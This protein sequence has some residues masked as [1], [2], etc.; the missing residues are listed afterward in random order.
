MKRNLRS[1]CN[2][3]IIELSD[4]DDD[5]YKISKKPK[6]ED[7]VIEEHEKKEKITVDKE[8]PIKKRIRKNVQSKDVKR[9]SVKRKNQEKSLEIFSN[10][11]SKLKA[12]SSTD[13]TDAKVSQSQNQK[14]LIK[15]DIKED[16][17]IKEKFNS[18]FSQ[19]AEWTDVD[20]ISEINNVDRHIVENVV[21]LFKEDNTIPFIARYRKNMTGSMEADQLR[22]LLDSFEQAK[23]IK[24]RAATIIKS[25]DK[26]G[27][28]SPE[29]HSTITS[30]KS[31]ADLEHIYSL[32]KPSAS[33]RLLAEKAR[34]LG[35]GS[36]SDAI[37]QG[38]KIAPLIF[39]VDEQREGLRNEQEVRSGIVH[40]IADLIS[41]D[42][43]IF[44]RV[45]S[46]RKT[47]VI[48]IHTTECKTTEDSKNVNGRK[49]EQYFN[50]KSRVNAIKPHHIL[51]IN[52]AESQKIISVKI[53]I[54]DAFERAFKECC[55]SRYATTCDQQER[56]MIHWDLLNESIDHAY[57]KLI[58][59]QVIRRVRS[60]MKE[61]AEKASIEVFATNVKQLLLTPPVRGK[62]VLGI[63]PGYRHGCKLA[64]VS[65]QGNVL[66]T[67]VIYPHN[68]PFKDAADALA[69]LVNK[70]GCA[71]IALGNATACRETELFLTKVIKSEMFN[72][73]NVMYTIVDECGASIYSCS[74]QAKSEFPDLDP[75]LVSA[76]SIA[77]RLQ[78]PLAELVKIEPKHLGVGMYQHD[79]PEA[80]LTKTLSEII[81]EVVS[82]VGVDINTASLYLL[83]Q[84][85]GLTRSRSTSIIEWRTKNGPFKNREELL[86]V[87]GIGSKTYE[88]CAGF[89]RILPETAT[90]S[91]TTSERKKKSKSDFNPLDQTW[92][93][94]E[95]YAIADKF[96]KHCQCKL[97][98][99]GTPA[100][101]ERINSQARTGYGKLAAQYGTDETTMET[102]IKAL[103]MQKDE[104]IRSKL[105]QPLFRNSVRRIEDLTVGTV[106]SG[107]VRNV[108][109]F[110][111]FVDVGVGKEG[112]IH[113]TRMK[114][115]LH[116]GQRVEVKVVNVELTRQ[117]IG[118]ELMS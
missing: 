56:E 86:N 71:I 61:Y 73:P 97:N 37:L 44:D 23:I 90:V 52:R 74:P 87:K 42:K 7:Y 11:K 75:N 81:T 55:L 17:K 48:E 47:S 34:A 63:D 5:T 60:E 24:N 41:K 19:C 43:Q 49:Y 96:V 10:K 62:I 105:S 33:R 80:Q 92:I 82:F 9:K 66:E 35:L 22:A 89:I 26:L 117:R 12:S 104:D 67:A 28:W 95:S 21:K 102:I 100:F 3:P 25:I 94:P 45:T 99:I 106:L 103:S 39:L 84:V 31:L 30:T 38:Q 57:K 4:S 2:Q 27:K 70:Y 88:Q 108:T 14:D 116:I 50:F 111:S 64:V 101:I 85:A 51:A 20:Y 68:N 72:T 107:V 53:V 13:F 69:R 109:H 93:H 76:I 54:P 110:G 83:Q 16:L 59:P 8:Q 77:R 6:D 58:K 79:L 91:E 65:G 112:L 29:L 118:L 1:K 32:Y 15:T 40:I 46:L 115:D 114:K 98:D 78:D 113:V 18:S 36:V